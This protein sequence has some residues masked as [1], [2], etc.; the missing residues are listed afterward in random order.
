MTSRIDLTKTAPA[1][2]EALRGLENYVH[3]SDL[4]KSLVTLVKL[5][6]SYLNRCA[7]CVDMHTKDARAAG[8]TEQRLY[9]VPVWREAPYFSERER[10]A[11]AWSELV[12]QLP[13]AG[14]PDSAYD[15]ARRE[16][17]ERELA[18]LTVVLLAINAWN[19]LKAAFGGEVGTYQPK[20]RPAA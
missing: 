4:P 7:Y 5:H 20:H 12:T 10:A 3:R 15:A 18:D 2:F 6:A 19:R 14:I 11:F 8:E 1:A 17:S 16:F 13:P 9:A